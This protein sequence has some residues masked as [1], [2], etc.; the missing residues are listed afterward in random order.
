MHPLFEIIH[1]NP[2]CSPSIEPGAVRLLITE[3]FLIGFSQRVCQN[4]MMEKI[5]K[6]FRF[7]CRTSRWASNVKKTPLSMY[8]QQV[9]SVQSAIDPEAPHTQY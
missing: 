6:V 1:A 8:L 5:L 2:G 4:M 3:C 9:Q 7:R